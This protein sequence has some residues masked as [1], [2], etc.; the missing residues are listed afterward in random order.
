MSS[1]TLW[2][3]KLPDRLSGLHV[4]AILVAF[5]GVIFTVNGLFIFRAL[6]TYTGEVANEPYRKGL[7]Y[8]SRIAAEER[9]RE[10]GYADVT[11]VAR[12][13]TVSV[14]LKDAAG[15][16]LSGI[17]LSGFVGRP[18]TDKQDHPLKFTQ[19]TTG[20]FVARTNALEAGNWIVSLHAT[21][22][23]AAN[24]VVYRSKRRVWLNP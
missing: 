8:N 3:S 5:F 22:D 4:L 6:S 19:N 10:L 9:Q 11:T 12:D 16:P 7:Q 24:E 17:A 15:M 13:G 18:S 23:T 14:L 1:E 20:Q 2:R 21:R